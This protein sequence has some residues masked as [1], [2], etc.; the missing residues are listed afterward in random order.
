MNIKRLSRHALETHRMEA[1]LQTVMVGFLRS[2]GFMVHES[3]KRLQQGTWI[4]PICP[5]LWVIRRGKC[6]WVELV[7]PERTLTPEQHIWHD[8]CRAQ[9]GRVLVAHDFQSLQAGLR[10]AGML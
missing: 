3:Q 5:N 2:M 6:A 4:T 1:D 9:G 7:H 10:E 8:T